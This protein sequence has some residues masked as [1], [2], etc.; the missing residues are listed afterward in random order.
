[1]KVAAESTDNRQDHPSVARMANDRV[2]TG[3]DEFV[4][5]L[6]TQFKRE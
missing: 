1:M 4:S 5:W 3:N 6:Y 2:W